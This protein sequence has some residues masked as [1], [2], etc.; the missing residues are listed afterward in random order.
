MATL[1][2]GSDTP[3]PRL[4]ISTYYTILG[5]SIFFKFETPTLLNQ[6]ITKIVLDTGEENLSETELSR[7]VLDLDPVT[8]ILDN[9][10]YTY[11]NIGKYFPSYSVTYQ[12]NDGQITTKTYFLE[13][14]I[15]V[16]KDWPVFKQ[17]D[18]RILGENILEL[19]FSFDNIQINPNE[20]GTSNV[21]NISLNRL[22]RCLEY[23]KSNTSILNSKTPSLYYGWL[24]VNNLNRANRLRWHTLDYLSEY[25]KEVTSV[26]GFSDI[27]DVAETNALF[28]VLNGNDLQIFKNS[29]IPLRIRFNNQDELL[30]TLTNIISFDISSDGKLLFVLDSV[31][32]KVYR[33]DIDFDATNSLYQTYNPILSLTHSIGSYGDE[34]DPFTFNNPIQ[35]LYVNGFVYVLDF[36]NKCVKTYTDKLEWIF[37]YRPSVFENDQPISFA[38]QKDSRFVYIMS[39]T[40]VYVFSH[41]SNRITSTFDISNLENLN[42]KKIFFDEVGEFFYIITDNNVFKYT[43]LGLFMDVLELPVGGGGS[44]LT[45]LTGK[46]GYGR[47]ILITTKTAII[48][49]QEITEILVTGQ[50]LDVDYWTID[51]ILISPDELSQD[52][53]I[54][55]ALSRLCYNIVN[56]RNSLESKLLISSESTP[57]GIIEYFRLYPIKSD[58]RPKLGDDVENNN[59]AVGVNELH[60]PSVINRELK[61][62]YNAL[63]VLKTF[64]DIENTTTENEIG[65]SID[66]C[67]NAFCWSWKAMSTYN[68][69]KPIIRTCNINPIS[70]RE[71]QRKFTNTDY[72][73]T[74]TWE[75]ATSTCC[76]NVA[77]PKF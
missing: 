74:K 72:V 43:A 70:F 28:F 48:K 61:K 19:P 57:A 11:K 44:N 31:Q 4:Y 63:L 23:L 59:V 8:P 24:G 30:S 6:K 68:I 36:N 3:E 56:F 45:F 52:L 55:R 51:Q 9:V 33:I 13:Q 49:C 60:T 76:S 15:T 35:I 18:I 75:E 12:A 62:L 7:L 77:V 20:F 10:T 50:G 40:K 67:P 38:V 2:T 46:F 39:K 42:P 27:R 71:L 54:N 17:Q 32:N 22:H 16:L 34:L 64:L 66:K 58:L 1:T 73:E 41:R 65:R 14:P 29:N 26:A 69:S 25:Y 47:N 53:V 21:Y 5:Q 37:T